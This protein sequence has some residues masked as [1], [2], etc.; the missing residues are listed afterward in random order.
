LLP[1]LLPFLLLPL[2]LC[3][4]ILFLY[5]PG[6]MPPGAAW[7]GQAAQWQ[8]RGSWTG[9]P[10]CSP[11]RVERRPGLWGRWAPL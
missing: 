4:F 8:R 5:T 1:L 6:F 3:S 11:P 10:R 2:S 9:W 7:R